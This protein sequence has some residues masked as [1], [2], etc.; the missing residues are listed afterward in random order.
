M[1][2]QKNLMTLGIAV[3]IFGCCLAFMFSGC[4]LF[5]LMSGEASPAEQEKSYRKEYQTTRSRKAMKWLLTNRV[6]QGMTQ[7][8]VS[9]IMGQEGERI[10]NDN[11]LKQGSSAYRRGDKTYRYGPDAEGRSIY[12]MFRGNKLVNYDADEF[13]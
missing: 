10:R 2:L 9:E 7:K 12:L 4:A 8:N 13:E 3:L 5:P 6:A 11:H 1:S